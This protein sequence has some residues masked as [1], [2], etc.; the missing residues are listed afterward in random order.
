MNVDLDHAD[1]IN[2]IRLLM[3]GVKPIYWL[4]YSLTKSVSMQTTTDSLIVHIYIIVGSK[5]L[6]LS[7]VVSHLYFPMVLM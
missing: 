5:V 1:I 2:G 3:R 7:T 4:G 6:W